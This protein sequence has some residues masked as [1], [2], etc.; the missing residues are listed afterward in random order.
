MKTTFIIAYLLAAI[1]LNAQNFEWVKSFGGA[2]N[3]YGISIVDPSGNVY[4]T[5]SFE[6]T[7]DFHP[8]AG[9]ANLSSAG[10]GDI[11]VQKMDALGN[12]L[13]A[14]SFGGADF[15]IG[16]SITVDASGNVYTTGYFEDTVDFDPGV[17]T[18]SLSA[19]GTSDI[20]V[21]KMDASGNF[22]W[23]K[24]F[25]SWNVD[26]GSS[27]TVDGS[28]NVYTAGRFTHIVDFDPGIETANLTSAGSSDMFIQKMDASGNFIWAKAFGGSNYD[29]VNS[30]QVDALENVYVTG[31]FQGIVDFDP[32]AGVANLSSEGDVDIFVQ[33]MDAS[34]NFLWAESFGS[35]NADVGS[36]ISVDAFGNIYTTGYF[37]GTVDFDPGA[38]T[39]NLSAIGYEDIFIQ[40]IDATGNFLWAKSFGGLADDN[41][42]SITIDPSGN[43]YT[44]GFFQGTVDFDPGPGIA[45]LTSAGFAGFGDIF[46]QKMDVSGNFLWAKAF[47][48]SSFDYG[49]SVNIDASGNV[50]TTGY[51]GGTGDFDPGDG[52]AILT[53]AG[54]RD[55]FA[56]KMSQLTIGI[57][58][59]NNGIEVNAYP[60][61]NNGLVQISFE[62]AISNVEITVTD[63]LGK[64][65]YYEHFNAISNEHINIDG[66][67]GIY[68]LSVK[69]AASRSVVKLI[70]E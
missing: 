13:W 41:A 38:G 26:G 45:N 30:I 62:Q 51:F 33:K 11:F 19:V 17:G 23:A 16:Y 53:S 2:D 44:T 15:D 34:G 49:Q 25:G 52:T 14:K 27:I 60:N 64:V 68:V 67:A 12:F 5:G 29:F 40:K 31:F 55:I 58:E 57:V 54:Q 35:S 4:T 56:Q 6:G 70:K 42:A 3:D 59:L 48:G 47:G 36:S 9:A 39:A 69:T 20:F 10:E 21:Q 1:T 61:P 24:S 43:V 7:V 32:G 22:L 50:Y 28:G 46:V 18:A 66:T 37:S 8:G 63:I 65:V